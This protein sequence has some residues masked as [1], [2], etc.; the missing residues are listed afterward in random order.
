MGTQQ[1]GPQGFNQ[2]AKPKYYILSHGTLEKLGKRGS[3]GKEEGYSS[4]NIKILKDGMKIII[5]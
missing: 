5:K 2:D 1:G 3:T 4:K